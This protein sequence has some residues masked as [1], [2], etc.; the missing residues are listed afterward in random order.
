MVHGFF[1]QDDRKKVIVGDVLK[2]G[3]NDPPC[4]LVSL[5]VVPMR[6]DLREFPEMI[7][8]NSYYVWIRLKLKN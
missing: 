3:P 4:L 5:L 6:V 8:G 2:L 1:A 7:Q